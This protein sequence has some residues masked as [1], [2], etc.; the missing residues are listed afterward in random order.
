LTNVIGTADASIRRTV[1]EWLTEQ[2]EERG[3]ALPRTLLVNFTLGGRRIPLLGPQGIWKPAACALPLSITT[4]IGGPY[5]DGWDEARGT[6]QYAYRGTDPN[7]R[8]NLGLRRAMVERV[9]LVYF[10]AIE[11][12]SYAAS[13]PAFVVGDNPVD[14]RF[15]VQLDDLGAALVATA[16]GDYPPPDDHADA[17]RAYV[18]RTVRQ[19]LHQVAFRERVIRAYQERCALCRLGHGELLDAAHITPDREADSEPV[20]SNGVALC[21]LHHAAFDRFFF[22]IRPDYMVEVRPSILT[23]S[24]GPMLVV[25]LQQIHGSRIG[26]PRRQI[27]LPDRDR[28]ARRYA[29]FLRAS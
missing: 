12:G 17:R 29:E 16:P 7:H 5:D 26:L 24:D 13:Y 15:T 11:P 6:L 8:D 19:R 25:G 18:T 22:A 23:E 28:L 1:F 27:H 9:P 21:K 14:L 4:V 20:V 2:R 3:E 10:L